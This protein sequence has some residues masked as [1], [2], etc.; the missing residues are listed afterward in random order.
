MMKSGWIVNPDGSIYHLKLRP[1]Q[2]ADTVITVGDP[3]RVPLVSRY[4]DTIE[5]KIGS[6]EFI[7]H[8][9]Y[10]GKKRLSV[11]STGI[12]TDNIDIV[13][14]ELDALWNLD[15][16]TFSQKENLTRAKVIR[17]GTSGAI[18]PEIPVDSLLLS[19]MAIGMD[20]LGAY[21]PNPW[22]DKSQEIVEEFTKNGLPGSPYISYAD[23]DL[24]HWLNVTGFATGVTLTAPG[25]YAPQG[26]Q[27]RAP[28]N[29]PDYLDKIKS[30]SLGTIGNITNI[31]METAGIYGL[32]GS[33]GHACLSVNAI[34]ANRS[35]GDFSRNPEATISRMIETVLQKISELP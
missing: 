3:D 32:G 2:V 14:N 19:R 4:L 8:T 33:L 17:L 6:R 20:A 24:L 11:L 25:F 30:I 22:K 13:L 18:Q 9:G 23:P 27:S 28:V 12:G 29:H 16:K 7:T 31:E 21:Y 34:L 15:L 10:L 26:R 35:T 5:H 1:D